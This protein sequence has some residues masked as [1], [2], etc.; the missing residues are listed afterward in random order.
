MNL[1]TSY[2]EQ[3]SVHDVLAQK[4]VHDVMALNN[5]SIEHTTHQK[6]MKVTSLGGD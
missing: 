5:Y 4:T 3:P 1:A 2:A 6:P